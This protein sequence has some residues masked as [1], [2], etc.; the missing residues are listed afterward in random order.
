MT[1]RVDSLRVEP[2]FNAAL[3]SLFATLGFLLAAIGLYGVVSFLVAA[4]TK[5]IGVRMALGA[6]PRS[7]L[8]IVLV[9]GLRLMLAGLVVGTALA[10]ALGHVLQ[11]LLYGVSVW[12]PIISGI[13]ALLLLLAGLAAC[14]I[15]A[16]RATK[17]DP[18]TALRYQ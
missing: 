10:F 4:R 1:A 8:S 3:I 11:G 13:A 14:Y 5:E 12:N 7:V 18:M 2:R 17:V 15:P 9:R 16:Y 6:S